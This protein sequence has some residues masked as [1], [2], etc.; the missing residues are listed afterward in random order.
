MADHIPVPAAPEVLPEKDQAQ[1][2]QTWVKEF[3]QAQID[4]PGDDT[5]QRAMAT[6]I[7]NRALN[8]DEPGSYEQAAAL[9][10]WQCVARA[11]RN[12]K[13][14]VVLINSKKFSFNVPAKAAKSAVKK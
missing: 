4:H 11:E 8:P 12:G 3:K 1:W 13:L 14:S 7:A 5:A 10:A 9:P 6:R 2:K